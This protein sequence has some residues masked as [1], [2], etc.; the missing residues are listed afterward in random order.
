MIGI[1][2]WEV[3]SIEFK[4][5][6]NPSFCGLI[7]NE[8]VRNYNNEAEEPFP[9]VYSFIALP[10]CLN[11]T[12]R[13]ALPKT[14]KTSFTVWVSENQP[15]LPLLHDRAKGFSSY[16]F[17]AINY[18]DSKKIINFHDNRLITTCTRNP[19][20]FN[21]FLKSDH[22]INEIFR[23]AAIIGKWLAKAGSPPLVFSLLGVCP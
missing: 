1:D 15:L 5:L 16:V 21:S 9:V 19:T 6:Y 18:M 3:S 17:A 2:T 23:K 14:T 11:K 7:L 20:G 13:S 4:N 12:L 10:I 22:E 8:I